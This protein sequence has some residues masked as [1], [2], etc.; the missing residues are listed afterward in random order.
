MAKVVIKQVGDTKSIKL[1]PT[2]VIKFVL[3]AL[4]VVGVGSQLGNHYPWGLERALKVWFWG[5]PL[6]SQRLSLL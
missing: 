1:V 4:E 2:Q 3:K 6:L 5:Y